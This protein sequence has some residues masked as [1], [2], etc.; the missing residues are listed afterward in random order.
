MTTQEAIMTTKEIA[1][2]FSQL[3]QQGNWMEIQK[4]LFDQN[5]V[6]IE[7]SHASSQGM[8]NAEGL[9][10]IQKKGELFQEMVEQMHGGYCS[11]PIIADNHFAVAMG[12][13]VTMKEKGRS[14]MDEIAVYE[15]KNGKIT[16]E[17]FFF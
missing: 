9:E 5:A 10:A 7:P 1:D 3:A 12:M 2:R 14:K 8:P 16:K 11:E 6:S 4:E 15:V 17:Q 13:D